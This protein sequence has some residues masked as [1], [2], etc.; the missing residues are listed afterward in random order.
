MNKNKNKKEEINEL[1]VELIHM[2]MVNYI[3]DF[4]KNSNDKGYSILENAGFKVGERIASRLT[5]DLPIFQNNM[6]ITKFIC[7]DFWK[8]CYQKQIDNLKTNNKGTYVLTDSNF[9]YLIKLSGS[10]EKETL[11]AAKHY[12][13]FPCGLIR[14]AMHSLGYF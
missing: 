6:D 13:I 5:K 8:E 11:E 7:R 14:G 4:H 2:E 3:L 1:T 9:K 10:N 12:V